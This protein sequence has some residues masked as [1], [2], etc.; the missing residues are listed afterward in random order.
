MQSEGV[1]SYFTFESAEPEIKV[2]D[3]LKTDFK[4]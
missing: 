3:L 2:Y 4:N 1:H